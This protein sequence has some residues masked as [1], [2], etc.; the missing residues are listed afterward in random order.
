MHHITEILPDTIK[1]ALSGLGDHEIDQ[2]EEIR[3]RTSRPLELV[4]K[5]KPRFLPYV[6]T[7]E[8]SALLLNRLGNYSMYTLE[9]ELKKD[10][11]RS[12]ADTAWGLPAGCRRNGAVKG[13]RE[14]SSFNIRIAKEKSAF[15]NRMSPFISNS[16]L[17]TLIIGPPQTGKQHCSET[18]PG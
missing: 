9:E 15:P 10:M 7:P 18:S 6:A 11:S 1:R 12:E 17:N 13:I 2:I 5:G 4:N 8:D 3:V 14:I 16:W